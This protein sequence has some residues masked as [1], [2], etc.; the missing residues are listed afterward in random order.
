MILVTP[1]D[2]V[3]PNP[4]KLRGLEARLLN[5]SAPFDIAVNAGSPRSEFLYYNEVQHVIEIHFTPDQR[6]FTFLSNTTE[7]ISES[8]LQAYAV[9][10]FGHVAMISAAVAILA[11]VMAMRFGY[12]GLTWP[13]S[14][15]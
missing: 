15:G 7:P 3:M 10:E 5:G 11:L 13:S 9:P 2:V 4:L 8:L 6:S 14:V 12:K 1:I